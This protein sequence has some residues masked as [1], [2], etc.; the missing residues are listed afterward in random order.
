MLRLFRDFFPLLPATVLIVIDGL[1]WLDD[2]ST[3]SYID[4]L[5]ETLKSGRFKLLLTS[6]GRSA[7][8]RK[9]VSSSETVTMEELDAKN[10]TR[11]LGGDTC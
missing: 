10:P 4:E 1:H 7:C 11:G 5:P 8:L 9:Q 6:N 2:R 3:V